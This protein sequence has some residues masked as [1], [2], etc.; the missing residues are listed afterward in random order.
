MAYAQQSDLNIDSQRIIELTDNASAPGV[1]D[2]A[3]LATLEAQSEVIVNSMLAGAAAAGRF[4]VPFPTLPSTPPVITLITAFIW[5]ARIYRH[6]EIM[7]LPPQIA[8]DEKMAF[9][10]IAQINAGELAIAPGVTPNL[11]G[12]PEVETSPARGWTPRDCVS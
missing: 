8:A 9:D 12:V 1:P 11:A 2:N 7:E 10:M 3:L 5:G 4:T 6:R